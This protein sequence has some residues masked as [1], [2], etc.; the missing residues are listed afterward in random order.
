MVRRTSYT[1]YHLQHLG[2]RLT[3][4]DRFVAAENA[5]RQSTFDYPF[6]AGDDR[7]AA[8]F[9]ESHDTCISPPTTRRRLTTRY[10]MVIHHTTCGCARRKVIISRGWSHGEWNIIEKKYAGPHIAQC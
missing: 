5:W 3:E 10:I 4:S 6:P 9:G 8:L 1:M 2:R 7:G